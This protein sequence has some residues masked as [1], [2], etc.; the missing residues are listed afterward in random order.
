MYSIYGL[1]KDNISDELFLPDRQVAS[2]DCKVQK[3]E[4]TDSDSE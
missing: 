2:A 1:S 4:V 3:T